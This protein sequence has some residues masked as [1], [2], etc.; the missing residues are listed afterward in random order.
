[1][2]TQFSSF[3][4]RIKESLSRMTTLDIKTIVGDFKLDSKENVQPAGGDYL[5]MESRINMLMGDITVRMSPELTTSRY[6]WVREFHKEKEAHGYQV[7]QN[8]IATILSLVNMY[9][10]LQGNQPLSINFP[11]YGGS[12]LTQPGGSSSSLP[13]APDHLA[14]SAF[15]NEIITDRSTGFIM[16]PNEDSSNPFI[17]ANP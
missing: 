9:H 5:I 4:E 11:N 17:P 10:Q 13:P 12:N 3:L 14:G 15:T 6:D 2:D 7:I 16:N 1:M 8:N